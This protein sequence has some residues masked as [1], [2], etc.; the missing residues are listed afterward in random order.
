MWTL[1]SKPLCPQTV[2]IF[3]F[4]GKLFL[5]GSHLSETQAAEQQIF[6]RK[7]LLIVGVGNPS[8]FHHR[9]TQWRCSTPLWA[10]ETLQL[11][12]G[13]MAALH[14]A[15]GK[16]AKKMDIDRLC[17]VRGEAGFPSCLLHFL[18]L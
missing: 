1:E 13:L 18:V 5:K 12:G 10:I 16:I 2:L 14:V 17:S 8:T 11:S 4:L 7:L 15:L 9:D 6:L 3:F